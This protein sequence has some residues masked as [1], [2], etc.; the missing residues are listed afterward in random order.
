M[1]APEADP[2]EV[3]LVTAQACRLCDEAKDVLTEVSH[4]TPLVMHEV[5]LLS[6]EGRQLAAAH[7]VPHVPLLFVDG[8]LFGYG[9]ISRRKLERHLERRVK[10]RAG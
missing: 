7:R 6:Y 9:R 8:V 3:V 5:P 1:L 2:V 10:D 4:H